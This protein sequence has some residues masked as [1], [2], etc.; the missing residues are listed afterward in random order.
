MY[1]MAFIS[2]VVAGLIV[3]AI[4]V[5]VIRTKP[6]WTIWQFVIIPIGSGLLS[7]GIVFTLKSFGLW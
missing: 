7:T 1:L 6:V 3:S 4:F 5:F 2:G